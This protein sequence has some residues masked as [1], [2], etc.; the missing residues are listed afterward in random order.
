MRAAIRPEP[1]VLT[2]DEAAALLGV[3]NREFRRMR[4]QHRLDPAYVNSR[5]KLHHGVTAKAHH[6]VM[7]KLHRRRGTI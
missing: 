1:D 7:A 4:P 2:T 6:E 3:D 5:A